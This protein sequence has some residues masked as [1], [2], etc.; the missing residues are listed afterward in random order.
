MTEATALCSDRYQVLGTLGSGGVADVLRVADRAFPGRVLALKRARHAA[1]NGAL[2]DEFRALCTSRHP[3]LPEPGEFHAD[4][5]DGT[6]GYTLEEVHGDAADRAVERHGTE[7]VPEVVAG[8][9]RALAALHARG[10]AHG[11]VHPRN[12]L[13]GG[14]PGALGVTL[15]DPGATG[16]G[17]LLFTSPERL[18]GEP[19]DGVSSDLFAVG[20]VLHRLVTGT[21]PFPDYPYL[22][23]DGALAHAD[24]LGA[25]EPL[26]SNLLARHPKDRPRS[27]AQAL[28]LLGQAVGRALPLFDAP[29]VAAS[30]RQGPTINWAGWPHDFVAEVV[31]RAP[32]GRCVRVLLGAEGSGRSHALRDLRWALSAQPVQVLATAASGADAAGAVLGRLLQGLTREAGALEPPERALFDAALATTLPPLGDAK[33][34]GLRVDRL[35][36]LVGRLSR[37]APTVLIVD[38]LDAADALSRTV[39]LATARAVAHR[40]EDQGALTLVAVVEDEAVGRA[41]LDAGGA[42]AAQACPPPVDEAATGALLRTV[43]LGRDGSSRLSTALLEASDGTLQGIGDVLADGLATGQIQLK[44]ELADLRDGTVTLARLRKGDRARRRLAPLPP[45]AHSLVAVLDAL[46]VPLPATLV[47]AALGVTPEAADV[48]VTALVGAGLVNATSGRLTLPAWARGLAPLDA[49]VWARL[50]DVPSEPSTDGAVIAAMADWSH[51]AATA[52]LGEAALRLAAEGRAPEVLRLATVVGPAL[53]SPS[54]YRALGDA[55][56]LLGDDAAALAAYAR[57]GG[58]AGA[59]LSGSLLVRRGRT[60]EA[61]AALEPIIDAPALTQGE[62]DDALAWLARAALLSSEYDHAL[63]TIARAPGA[64]GVLQAQLSYVEGLVGFYRGDL[65]AA[66][67]ALER[68]QATFRALDRLVEQADTENALGLVRFRAGDLNAACLRFEATLALAERTGDRERASVTLMNLAVVHQERGDYM[69]AESRYREALSL[70][71]VL[72]HRANVLKVIQNLGNLMRFLGRLDAAR[73]FLLETV[74]LAQEPKTQ[75][76]YLEAHARCLLGEVA[77]LERKLDAAEAELQAALEAFTAVGSVNEAA[78]ARRSLA[79]VARDRGDR[80][81]CDALLTAAETTAREVGLARLEALCLIDR[82]VLTPNLSAL[83]LLARAEER[84]AGV[85]RPDVRWE[86]DFARFR[87]HRVLGDANAALRE[88]RATW[89][90]LD[91]LSQKLPEERRADFLAVRNRAEAVA[92]TQWLAQLGGATEAATPDATQ[93]LS[94]LLDVTQRL[95][96]ELDLGKLLEYLIDSAIL[97]TGAERGFVL[98]Q[99]EAAEF[100]VVVARNIDRENIKNK[101]YKVSYSIARQVVT[102]GEAVLTTDAT[103]DDRYSQTLS[104]AHMKLR[105]VLCVPM[106]RQGRVLGALYLDNRFQRSAFR[107]ED[108]AF[109]EAF[110]AQAAV[111]LANARLHEER[112]KALAA[113]ERSR[114]EVEVLNARLAE[115]LVERERQLRDTEALLVAERKQVA[116]AHGFERMLGESPRL[117][118]V[119]QILSRVAETEVPVLITGQSGT[120]KE[121]AARAI[122]V[123]GS[124]KDRA[125]IAINCSSIP[126]TLIESELFGHVRG[127][128]TGATGDKKGVFEAA[129]RGTLFLDEIGEMPLEM[130]AKL[131]RVLQEGEIQ[132]VGSPRAVKVDVRIVAA[133]NRNVREMIQQKLFREDLFYRIAV[134]TVALPSLAERVED[135]P[136]LVQSFLA[137]NRAEGFSRVRDISPE[138]LRMLVRHPWPGNV[139][140][141]EMAVKNACIFCDGETLL[142]RDFENV[143]SGLGRP[144]APLMGTTPNATGAVRPLADL[145][146][147]AIV[148]ALQVLGGNKKRAAE[149]LG[150]DRRTLYNKLETYGIVVERRAHVGEA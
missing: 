118:A 58:P 59:M 91:E 129:D 148:H 16:V 138:A 86:L 50:A 81:T 28:T 141:L 105:S 111:A 122:H 61:M 142:P 39:L 10:V 132:K 68:A 98:L 41:L 146:R 15:L 20:V 43:L 25:L 150:I 119:L 85:H 92:E 53:E 3:N 109:M 97:L 113:L 117:K 63:A 100:D 90:A 52:R 45:T 35:A 9:L 4:L 19:C 47:A 11:D 84:L 137:Q 114:A 120:G 106:A 67:T 36:Q 64:T 14:T 71:R 62:R 37:A 2:L 139:R 40:P 76:R 135:I 17:A 78:D 73:G 147:E 29:T 42:F 7:I 99:E 144:T 126:E 101:R 125:F 149:D 136:L 124:R 143:S 13:V 80:S 49:T 30:L 8:I 127:S 32:Q 46:P 18:A 104:V 54:G 57:L 72:D 121:L 1:S 108:Q 107:E 70:S 31:A 77:W 12:V 48:V 56:A 5:G 95:A 26:V 38:A 130:Q 82:A 140:E 74:A 94:R 23:A 69:L 66:D 128:F 96:A 21:V 22:P 51:T 110:A 89:R 145:E 88:G 93:R 24:R 112:T 102:Q 33:L 123:N 87:V 6:A 34:E 83:P 65:V 75:N 79:L 44:D 116:R 55:N 60:R 131:L 115:Q 134:V 27:A 133:T 103:E